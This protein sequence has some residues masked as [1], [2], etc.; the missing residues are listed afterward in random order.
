MVYN[1]KKRKELYTKM[2]AKELIEKLF[3]SATERDLSKGCDQ[4]IAGNPEAEVTK[5][6]VTM[7]ATPNIIKQA[8][9]WGAELIITQQYGRMVAIKDGEITS[10]TLEEAASQTKFLPV[11]H[12]MIQMAR[13]IGICFG[14]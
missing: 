12:P 5:V 1:D 4:L 8:K 3:L 14:D 11:D 10:I 6:A 7:F 2:K 9:E 13:D